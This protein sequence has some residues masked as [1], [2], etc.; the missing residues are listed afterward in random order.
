M[1]ENEG[2][3]GDFKS[4]KVNKV[5]MIT[6][7]VICAAMLV[8]GLYLVKTI[9][10]LHIFGM[11]VIVVCLVIILLITAVFAIL[12]KWI[13]P[14]IIAKVISV[15]LIAIMII[16]SI[17]VN[18]TYKAID[19]MA[20]VQ[21]QIDNVNVYVM[22]DSKY[23][24]LDDIKDSGFGVMSS[25]DRD[26]TD[27]ALVMIAD[28]LGR[29]VKTVEYDDAAALVNALYDGNTDAVILNSA[30]VPVLES[31]DGFEDVE[32]R[33]RPVWSADIET[34]VSEAATGN[35]ETV[36][37]ET[38]DPYAEYKDYL[39]NGDDVFTVYIS[40]IDTTGEPTVNRNSDVNILMTVNT[41]TRQILMISTPRDYYVP[42][43]I[44]DGVKDKLTHA[45]C[46]GIDVSVDTLEMLY[47]VN[48]DDYLKV[49]FTGFKK[50]IDALGGV[51]VYS[52][53]DFTAVSGEKFVKG[54]NYGLSGTEALAFARERH[55]FPS[56][57]RQ[58]GKNQ[59][60]V[61]KAVINKMTSSDMLLN[62]TD[63]LDALSDSM[64][65]SMSYERIADLVKFQ[66]SD[67]KG[68]D[69]ITY[70]ADGKGD[71]LECYSLH[72][73]VYVMIPTQETVDKAKEYLNKIYS[74]ERIQ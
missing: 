6:G 27:R 52:E 14:G 4:L 38:E 12:Q 23:Q 30:F 59:M 46:Y 20:G 35:H 65:T 2:T 26:N 29:E 1:N 44:S 67:M 33:I 50:I 10:G 36:P 72:M 37:E 17:Y 42:L 61:I 5:L 60:A 73:P 22:S 32:S 48:I 13:V 58:R 3:K 25:I 68:W 9:S 39:Y 71:N 31:I 66:L 11:T 15:L 41:T 43:S 64:V 24:N 7:W 18:T 40:G 28:E 74:G 49:N 63:V 56:G 45:G 69:V 34:K 21:T 16:G 70:S 55:A 8:V 62:Y 57:D 19:K 53:Y 47:G 54:Y 51:D